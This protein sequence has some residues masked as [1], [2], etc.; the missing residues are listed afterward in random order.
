MVINDT[1]GGE[2]VKLLLWCCC[3][4]DDGAVNRGT[5]GDDVV[6]V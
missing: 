6:G 5:Q 4:D 3:G 1:R 2:T